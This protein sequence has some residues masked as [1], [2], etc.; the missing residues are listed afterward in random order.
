MAY[1]GVHSCVFQ[2]SGGPAAIIAVASLTVL[3]DDPLLLTITIPYKNKSETTNHP[4]YGDYPLLFLLIPK[5]RGYTMII[6]LINYYNP[7]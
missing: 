4:F 7:L 1:W 6:P 5:V 3:V 2:L